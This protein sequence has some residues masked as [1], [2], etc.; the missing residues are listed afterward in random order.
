MGNQE[1]LSSGEI[2]NSGEAFAVKKCLCGELPKIITGEQY[3]KVSCDLCGKECGDIELSEA[4]TSWNKSNMTD[5]DI[6]DEAIEIL[7]KSLGDRYCEIPNA[8]DFYDILNSGCKAKPNGLGFV[9]IAHTI[10]TDNYKI[11]STKDITSRLKSLKTGNPNI[12][13]IAS[14]QSFN[15]VADEKM[16]HSI[17]KSSRIGGEWFALTFDQIT[18][19]IAKYGFN[20]HVGS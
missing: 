18:D 9:Y 8:N 12:S 17:F 11:G 5:E 1:Y 19:A 13:M 7:K 16:L 14:R 20:Y 10:G 3:N 15:R 6:L 4:V 2:L